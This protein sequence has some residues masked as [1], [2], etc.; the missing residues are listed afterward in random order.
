MYENTEDLDR[1][2]TSSLVLTVIF[3]Q[4][5]HNIQS[6]V[7]DFIICIAELG[8]V[9]IVNDDIMLPYSLVL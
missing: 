6:R 7:R 9:Q 2:K 4:G 1:L 3:S 5:K 8:H